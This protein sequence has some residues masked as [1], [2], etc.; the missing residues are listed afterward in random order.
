MIMIILISETFIRFPSTPITPYTTLFR[1]A[2]IRRP[3]ARQHGVD[4]ART[5][6]HRR[7]A[8]H[9]RY[10]LGVRGAWPHDLP[11][12]AQDRKSTRLNSSHLVMS[13]AVFCLK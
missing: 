13:Y 5:R 2:L 11:A 6:R 7:G 9:P 10:R 1:S 12:V 8:R 3:D 4:A